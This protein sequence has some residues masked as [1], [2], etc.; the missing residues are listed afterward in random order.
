MNISGSPVTLY[1]SFTNEPWRFV[2]D[3]DNLGIEFY[4]PTGP[5]VTMAPGEKILLIKNAIFFE[6]EY[7]SLPTVQYY[8]W[9]DGSLSNGGEKPEIQMPG[10]VDEFGTR[11]YIR[12]DRVSYDD[13]APWP[14]EPD[15]EGESLTRISNT[16]YG[17]DVINWQ[18]AEASPGT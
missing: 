8:E 15:G 10:D 4:L 11:Y 6:L 12:V 2:D 1:D 16:A 9:L 5:P 7:G 13:V 3:E 18:S 14:T 17:N